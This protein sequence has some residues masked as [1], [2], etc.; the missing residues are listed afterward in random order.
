M[1]TIFQN[2]EA[3]EIDFRIYFHDFPQSL[4]LSNQRQYF[5]T[6]C[7]RFEDAFV[8]DC[9]GGLLPPYSF[10]EPRYFNEGSDRANDQHP[11]HGVVLGDNLIADVYDAMRASP[12]WEKSLLVVTWDEH[13][14]FY[15]HVAPPGTT[16][17]GDGEAP[18]FDFTRLGVRV[19]AIL[20][21]P[22]IPSRT[23]DKS[24][25]DH[26]S[27]CT[28]LKKI[29]NLPKFLT[30]RD[31]QANTFDH[32]LSLDS[33][34]STL[35]SLPRIPEPQ[36]ASPTS[37]NQLP[38]TELHSSLVALANSLTSGDTTASTPAYSE[39]E[40]ARIVKTALAQ[41]KTMSSP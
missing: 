33:A 15:D 4:A 9:K 29:F 36:A 38:P 6:K 39:Q 28:T 31:A 27:I 41:Y 1:K 24:V 23:V 20:A 40:A 10:I 19:P 14:G 18:E 12:Q 37:E 26:S 21:S 5:R 16:N 30:D 3:S 2:L 35:E 34:R 7:E 32:V 13:G 22:F 11:I 17:P 8:R 25:Y